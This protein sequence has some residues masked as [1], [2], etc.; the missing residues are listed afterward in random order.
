MQ[1]NL[2]IALRLVR[3][4]HLPTTAATSDGTKVCPEPVVDI[5]RATDGAAEQRLID[6]IY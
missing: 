4:K 3:S 2:R 1:S 6:R 5:I